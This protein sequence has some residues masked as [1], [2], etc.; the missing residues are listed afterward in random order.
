MFGCG[1][2]SRS[3]ADVV[4][5][6]E[7]GTSLVFVDPNA[8]E[9]E[10]IYGF[11][12]VSEL[13]VGN[14]PV[15]LAIGDNAKRREKLEELETVNLVPVVS[16]KAHIG[17]RAR[18]EAGCFIGN[19]CHIGPETVIGRNTIVNNAAVVEHEVV[20]GEHCHVGPNV[21]ISGRCRIGDEVFVGVGATIKDYVNVCSNVVIGAG[22]TVVKDIVEPGTYV[23]TPARRIK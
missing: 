22:A 13:T 7:P 1:G 6:N 8:R 16:S 3:V 10:V 2:H 14:E 17:H 5:A 4:L 19:F 18:V 11:P 23:G 12:V 15:F 21:T 20:V 9:N